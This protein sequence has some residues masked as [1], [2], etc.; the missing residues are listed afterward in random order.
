[1]V[2]PARTPPW[3]AI[4]GGLTLIGSND[5]PAEEAPAH[6]VFVPEFEVQSTEVTVAAYRRCVDSKRCSIPS[7]GPGCNWG[8]SNQQHPINCVSYYDAQDYCAYLDASLP[9]ESQWE[10]A[11]RYPDDRILPW[12][13]GAPSLCWN[14][15]GTCTIT[16]HP[17][18]ASSL[19][20]LGLSD[21]VAEW[22]SSP[23]VPYLGDDTSTLRSVR[24]GWFSLANPQLLRS[25]H[26]Q[27][28]HKGTE[29]KH[30]GF[31]CVR[32]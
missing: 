7:S 32:P 21:N 31:R 12:S 27:G 15:K 19:G 25:T 14:S 11:A 22:T 8:T 3:I 23:F 5:G 24:G 2:A 17:D 13:D 20:V 4:P 29:A 26:R 30:V 18:A 1:M 6:Y 10:R 28:M 16:S 9:S